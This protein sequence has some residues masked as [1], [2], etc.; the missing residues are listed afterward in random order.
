MDSAVRRQGKIHGRS[1]TK[2]GMRKRNKTW[3]ETGQQGNVERG[4]EKKGRLLAEQVKYIRRTMFIGLNTLALGGP[5]IKKKKSRERF[6]GTVLPVGLRANRK[7][8]DIC[9]NA[10]KEL[11]VLPG[12]RDRMNKTR[13]VYPEAR[14]A[15]GKAKS[16]GMENEF[17]RLKDLCLKTP[18]SIKICIEGHSC[19][20]AI[21]RKRQKRAHE[22]QEKTRHNKGFPEQTGVCPG[23]KSGL[24]RGG[25]DWQVDGVAKKRPENLGAI[26]Y[27]IIKPGLS[28]RPKDSKKK[29]SDWNVRQYCRRKNR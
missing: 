17:D 5:K 6:V 27:V 2:N 22:E 3:E 19:R 10:W 29:K 8:A 12:S 16:S 24:E 26:G 18:P 9:K 4:M 11:E 21:T 7:H 20:A 25:R 28:P 23:V 1:R 14:K 15:D 13:T